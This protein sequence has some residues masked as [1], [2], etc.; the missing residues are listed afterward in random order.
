MNES[1]HVAPEV[2][3]A[4]ASGRAVV[5]LEST[6]ITHGLPHPTN[7]ETALAME[8]AVRESGAVPATIAVL[9]G[10]ITVGISA[11]DIERLA[12][13]P[14]DRV[15]KCSRR[16]LPIAAALGE[17]ASTTV[18]AT[19][20]VAQLAG[21]GIFAT[22]GIGGVHRGHPFDVSA[23]LVELGRNPVAVVCSGAKAILDLPLTVEVL[24]TQGVAILGYMTSTF[25]GFY[26]RSTGL[27]VD[28]TVQTPEE[29]ARIIA[30]AR[31][32]GTRQG[33]LVAVPVP[34]PDALPNDQVERA[35]AAALS[36]AESRGIR[37]KAVTPFLLE[38][39][40]ELSGGASRRANIS[41][42]V[43]NARVA[44]RIASA[45]CRMAGP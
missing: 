30:A 20:I 26:T 28:V 11:K 45:L 38:R 39:V 22:G 14:R 24:E 10:K 2:A 33:L 8:A 21:I 15:R 6:L 32:L 23:D 5:A 12:G 17:D 40:A 9:R 36:E 41:L 1:I 25:P 19:L 3:D 35:V 4:L 43:N 16:D 31:R 18:A 27:P 37:G 29:A 44:G 34:E 42:L 7:V 13:L